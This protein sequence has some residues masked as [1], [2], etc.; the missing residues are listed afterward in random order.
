[1]IGLLFPIV[2][3]NGWLVLSLLQRLQPLVNVFIVA[4]LL[5]FILNY[6]VRFLQARRIQRGYAV[7]LV[8]VLALL[9]LGALVG[10]VGPMLIE[11]IGEVAVL[12]PKW[13]DT[14]GA[15]LQFLEAWASA[16]NL[17]FSIGEAVAQVANSLPTELRA[18]ADEVFSLTLGTLGGLSEG[19]LTFVL[20]FYLLIDGERLTDGLFH[21][22]P[23][24]LGFKV[25][26]SLQQ[27]FQNYFIGQATIAAFMGTAVTI[28]LLALKVPYALLLGMGIGIMAL[29]PFGDLLSFGLIGLLIASQNFWLGMKVIGVALLVD[30]F[31]DHI[32]APRLL[33]SFTGLRPVGVI[34]SLLVGA[35]LGGVL[36][37][38]I[39]VPVVSFVKSLLDGFPDVPTVFDSDNAVA[40]EV[41]QVL[42][43]DPQDAVT[44]TFSS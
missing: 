16:Q 17:P 30:Q 4:G 15:K 5:A 33:G 31:V 26:Q 18:I 27:N 25:Q 32:I 29:I 42:T 21:R 6:P 22:L 8:L 44:E 36:G 3:L 9:L 14:L 1:M 12:I 2:G 20:T 34:T 40:V 23:S 38:L 7:L 11:D 24:G 19:I 37:L 41:P 28:T 10:I 43:P 39:A 13:F 35:K